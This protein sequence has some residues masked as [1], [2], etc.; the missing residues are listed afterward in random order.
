[1]FKTS[2]KRII[3]KTAETA[4]DLIGNKIANKITRISKTSPKRNSE[5]NQEEILRGRYIYITRVKTEN[6][7]RF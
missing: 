4:G 5:T 7:W 1:M 2:S 6:Y 3:Q